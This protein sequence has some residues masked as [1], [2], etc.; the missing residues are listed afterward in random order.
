ME[1]CA[2]CKTTL[3]PRVRGNTTQYKCEKC[4]Y[5]VSTFDWGAFEKDKK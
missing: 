4:P 3:S 2:N 1:V 5:S